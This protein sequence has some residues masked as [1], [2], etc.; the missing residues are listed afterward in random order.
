MAFTQ[1]KEIFI[2]GAG[3]EDAL[4]PRDHGLSHLLRLLAAQVREACGVNPA[5]IDRQTRGIIETVDAF[6]GY[7]PPVIGPHRYKHGTESTPEATRAKK[8]IEKGSIPDL[9]L[10]Q[11]Q[12]LVDERV[13]PLE[14]KGA[15]GRLVARVVREQIARRTAVTLVAQKTKKVFEF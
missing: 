6:Y 13:A 9:M 2:A 1:A 12:E 7:R 5:R 8:F 14:E 10:A 3:G 4:V 15:F 11:L